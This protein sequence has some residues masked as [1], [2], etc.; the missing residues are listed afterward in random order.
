MLE[1]CQGSNLV[2]ERYRGPW[3]SK[4]GPLAS[5]MGIAQ[6]LVRNANPTESETQGGFS[7]LCF[8]KPSRGGCMLKCEKHCYGIYG[9]PEWDRPICS[10]GREVEKTNEVSAPMDLIKLQR[11]M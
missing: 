9:G 10:G 3:F 7:K 6:E 5:H 1:R 2:L 4:N 11:N 8:E